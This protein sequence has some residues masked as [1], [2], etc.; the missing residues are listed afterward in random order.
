MK[1]IIQLLKNPFVILPLITIGLVL[2]WRVYAAPQR[3][4][5]IPSKNILPNASFE[6]MSM[7]WKVNA[8]QTASSTVTR[9]LIDGSGLRVEIRNDQSDIATI[10]TPS[11]KLTEN[12]TYIFKS[13]YVTDVAV[14]IFTRFHFTDGTVQQHFLKHL[15]DYDYPLSTMSA[16]FTA[17][18]HAIAAEM[19]ISF[20]DKG[21]IELDS[22]YVIVDEKVKISIPTNENISKEDLLLGAGWDISRQGQVEASLNYLPDRQLLQLD[23]VALGSSAAI[24][25]TATTPVTEHEVIT[26]SLGYSSSVA[27]DLGI[28]TY[29]ADSGY[30]YIVL[31]TL[32][33][34]T[35]PTVFEIDFEVPAMAEMIRPG[36]HI[37]AKGSVELLSMKAQRKTAPAVFDAPRISI[38]FDDGWESSYINGAA[39]LNARAMP[40]TFY[41]NPSSIGTEAFMSQEQVEILM[42][43]GH[44]IASHGNEHIDMTMYTPSLISNDQ[45]N[46]KRYFDALGIE[47]LDFASPYGKYD[48][49]ISPLIQ[50]LNRSHRGTQSGVNT[51][52]NFDQYNLLALFVRKET[53]ETQIKEMIQKTKES[54]GW[55]ILIYH[56]IEASDSLFAVDKM[57]FESHMNIVNDSGISVQTVSGALDEL[58][59]QL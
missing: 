56:H 42:H 35:E 32:P 11:F 10:E 27:V 34:V 59:P 1:K 17:P 40:G 43:D 5:D 22:A 33:A 50:K 23:S 48:Q 15:P 30:R 20:K 12:E 16:N 41:I 18:K 58:A 2:S 47:T 55:L 51:K 7:P 31:A 6:D 37:A 54:N 25:S 36:L 53:T 21:Y 39:I 57:T 26:L 46:A 13:Y 3:K 44:Q 49:T 52:Q 45:N 28:D 29:L 19:I 8:V 9:G 24:V 38:T 4:Y 14:T